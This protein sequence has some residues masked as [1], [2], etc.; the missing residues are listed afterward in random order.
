MGADERDIFEFFTPVAGKVRDVQVIRDARTGRSKGVGYVEMAT[1][2]GMAKALGLSGRTMK[3]S[4]I[5]VQPTNTY[6]GGGSGGG[7]HASSGLSYRRVG[8]RRCRLV[9]C[10]MPKTIFCCQWDA[11]KLNVV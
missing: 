2:E 7:T 6:T 1:H 10:Q 4:A 3:G 8:K 5:R 9:I 11:C